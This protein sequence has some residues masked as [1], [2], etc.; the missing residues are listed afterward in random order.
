MEAVAEANM[1][2]N[3]GPPSSAASPTPAIDPEEERKQAG[4]VE[5]ALGRLRGL[6]IDA[7]KINKA[8]KR[9]EKAEADVVRTAKER[10]RLRIIFV[11]MLLTWPIGFIWHAWIALYIFLAW[12]SVWGVGRYLSWGHHRN[13]VDRLAEARAELTALTLLSSGEGD[14]G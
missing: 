12:V 3:A 14:A 4:R 1:I 9:L 6:T 7:A 2:E 8:R 13:A 5:R 11:P 10:D